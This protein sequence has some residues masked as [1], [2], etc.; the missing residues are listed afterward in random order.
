M[1]KENPWAAWGRRL[2]RVDVTLIALVFIIS[3][4]LIARYGQN[5]SA[6]VTIEREAPAAEPAV[7]AA[8]EAP[9]DV[10]SMPKSGPPVRFLMHNVQNYFVVGEKSRSRYANRIKPEKSRQ[11]VAEVIASAKPDVVGLVE[12][13]GPLALQDLQARLREQGCDLPHSRILL[14]EGEDRALA[15]LSRYPIV[16]DASKADYGL[17]GQ[18][19]RRM[20]R[21]ILDV[22]VR[23]EDGRM[24]RIV[25]AHLKSRVA[26]DAEAAQSLRAREAR[27]LAMYLQ[28]VMRRQPG[29][30]VLVYGDWNDGPADASLGVL[31]QG[32]SADSA[33]QRLS[34]EDSDGDVWTLYYKEDREYFTFDQIYVNSVLRSR[35]GRACK[36]GIVDI[37]AAKTASDH[38]AVWCDVR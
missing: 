18:Q 11:A 16:Q 37:P 23:V 5:E 27:T 10:A 17:F 12:V 20:L 34:P 13:G 21:G 33:L 25:G 24:F 38:R 2:G 14:R 3:S 9:L 6:P 30:P 4:L 26:D 32:I 8:G 31:T 7:G 15:V 36:S 19:R 22:T 35:R 28:Q 1:R 29:M